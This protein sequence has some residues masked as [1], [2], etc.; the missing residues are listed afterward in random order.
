[1]AA[2]G[3]AIGPYA[4]RPDRGLPRPRRQADD[5]DWTAIASW[6]DLLAQ[7]GD[8]P[9]VEVDFAVAHGRA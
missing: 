5:T 7:L 8:K 2:G 1:M 4:S 6:Y 9:V 3:R